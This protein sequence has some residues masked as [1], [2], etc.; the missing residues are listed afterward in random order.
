MRSPKVKAAQASGKLTVLLDS[1]IRSG[2]D[3]FRAIALGAQGV[4]RQYLSLISTQREPGW[5]Y[6]A[7]FL[8][9]CTPVGRLYAYALAIAGQAGVEAVIKG[10]LADFELTLGLAGYR[11]IA[12]IQGK[13]GEVMIKV[14]D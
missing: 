4:L 5:T 2:S 12:E 11:S 3:I 6:S 8:S 10:I 9:S 7:S 13:A 1:G 14:T